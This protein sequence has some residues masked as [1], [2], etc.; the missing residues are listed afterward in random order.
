M[1]TELAN[2]PTKIE[3]QFDET[4]KEIISQVV[5]TGDLKGLTPAQ[6]TQY[7]LMTCQSQG[8]NPLL[9][10][11]YYEIIVFQK[12]EI[13]YAKK[14]LAEALRDSRNIN[15][16]IF[17]SQVDKDLG[18]YSV[19]AVAS[20]PN[21]RSEESLAVLSIEVEE[22][23]GWTRTADGRNIPKK[24]GKFVAARGQE[25][26][27]LMMKCETKAK[28][29]AT[30]ALCGLGIEERN[31]ET[32]N[33]YDIDDIAVKYALRGP[34]NDATIIDEPWLDDN[35]NNKLISQSQITRLMAIAQT[36][37]CLITKK[38]RPL[39]RWKPEQIDEYIKSLGFNSKKDIDENSYKSICEYFDT[40][41]FHY[42]DLEGQIK[43]DDILQP[44]IQ[45]E[46]A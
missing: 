5:A 6:K 9:A 2:K 24:T 29:R 13:L 44:E 15:C 10:A 39:P 20:L 3:I 40:H 32:E 41:A 14:G 18:L 35:K 31:F 4:T 45:E 8:L 1:S 33:V 34:D 36:E 30:L 28:R 22:T 21:G 7:I 17:S 12:K 43:I 25:L 42:P 16:K 11:Q 23:D 37:I 46:T 19:K 27:N 26:A 38:R